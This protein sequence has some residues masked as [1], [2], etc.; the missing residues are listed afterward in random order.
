VLLI[1][2]TLTKSSNSKI[3]FGIEQDY[4]SKEKEQTKELSNSFSNQLPLPEYYGVLL[5]RAYSG[6]LESNMIE[7]G[8]PSEDKKHLGYVED[9]LDHSRKF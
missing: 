9:N 5:E 7:E 4:G 3:L 1:Y 6:T 8:Q 2:V